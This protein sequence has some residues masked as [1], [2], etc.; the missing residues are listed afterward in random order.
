M[1]E[2]TISWGLG[3]AIILVFVV[4]Y[5]KNWKKRDQRTRQKLEDAQSKGIDKALMQHPIIDLST[6]IGCG[7]CVRVCPEGEVLGLISGKAV[8]VNGAK[9]VGHELC[10]DNCPVGGIEVGL[11]DISSRQDIPYLQENYESNIPGL[12]IVGEL[13]GLALIRNAINQGAGV[14]RE[15]KLTYA[16]RE[17]VDFDVIVVGAGPAGMS[18]ALELVD[19]GLNVVML[20]QDEPGGTIL[21]YPRRKL[22]MV[23]PVT[24]PHYGT[25]KNLEYS[26]EELLEIWQ[27]I[28]GE[29]ELHYKSHHRMT[30]VMVKDDIFT[31]QTNKGDF[32]AGRVVLALG[33]RGTPR[34]LGVSGEELPKVM[35]K[36]IDTESYQNMDILVVGGGDSAI[37]AAIGLA[38]QSGN[39]VTLSYRKTEFFRLKSKN[40][41]RL[42][43]LVKD[44]LINVIFESNVQEIKADQVILTQHD[45]TITLANDHIFVFAGGLVPFPLLKE[46]GIQFGQVAA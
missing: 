20:D 7:I 16:H 1:N 10:K 8:L 24:L 31:V 33:R 25:L 26:K 30:G 18:T 5:L 32:T 38:Q 3:I 11:G 40:Q 43:K 35:Y 37:E 39:R 17:D 34:K 9:C 44:Q 12:Y 15:I 13:G 27:K 29:K 42:D 19:S 45:E 14:G 2:M 6:C 36:L 4:P 23:Q 46:I 41:E 22:V 21:Q 28:L